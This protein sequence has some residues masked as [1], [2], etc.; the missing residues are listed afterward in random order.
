MAAGAVG[1]YFWQGKQMRFVNLF[2]FAR[3]HRM[4]PSALIRMTLPRVVNA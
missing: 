1:S 4:M 3:W 2:Y